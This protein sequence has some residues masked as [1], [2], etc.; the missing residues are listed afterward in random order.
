MNKQKKLFILGAGFT[1]R[2]IAREIRDKDPHTEIIAFLD[3]DIEKI[4][5]PLDGVPVLGPIK[6]C[7][8]LLRESQPDEALIAIPSAGRETLKRIYDL[9]HLANFR[10][11]RIIP[12]L[13]HIVHGP[14]HLVQARDI[15]PED[16]LGRN[17]VPIDLV[18]TLSYLKGKRVLVTG[19]GGSIGSEL[20]RQ[21]LHAGAERIYIL[22][23]G[24]NSIYQ[25]ERELQRL[26]QGGIGQDAI[27][28]PVIGELQD[29][30]FMSFIIGR[31]KA[32]YIFH[33]AA[34]KHV[35][36]MEKNPVE[37]VKNNVF[38]TLNLVEAVKK[39]HSTRMVLISTD[40]AVNPCSVYGASKALAEGLLLSQDEDNSQFM[41][42]RF[43]NV[44][45]ARGSILPL[46]KEQILQGGP[47][48]ITHTDMTRFYM[49]IPEA[50]SLVLKTAGE[51][52]KGGLYLLDM[53]E[54]LR[55]EEMARQM[56]KFYGFD[57]K[58]IPFKYIGLREGEKLDETLWDP[59]L[60]EPRE[61]DF[62]RIMQ[63]HRKEAHRQMLNRLIPELR[64]ICFL[65]NENPQSYRNRRH[66]RQILSAEF[67]EIRMP[68][69]EP[70]Y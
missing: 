66:L 63:I 22:G 55:I 39:A 59:E 31:L 62:P 64:K 24:E 69:D 25:L 11:I 29:R 43:G 38:G 44:M 28:V 27:I 56:I 14:V 45:G 36:M 68:D 49:T 37:A 40:K 48:T 20:S 15:D 23:H 12:S 32:D 35:P 50:V 47:V 1:G 53:G 16:L 5:K 65:D 8:T 52:H 26:Q 67:S 30:D 42:V 51:G 4:G 7:A 9:L 60:E 18:E 34:H 46:F 54:P 2:S 61:T 57:E 19:A 13:S 70:E 33:T 58:D 41:V 17:P 21:L 10:R 3:D 6:N